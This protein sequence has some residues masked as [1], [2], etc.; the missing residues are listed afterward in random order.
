MAN[1]NEAWVP[2][3]PPRLLRDGV[4]RRTAAAVLLRA[5]VRLGRQAAE[6][7][8]LHDATRT[9]VVAHRGAL[10]GD[11]LLRAWGTPAFQA[12]VDPLSAARL[13]S[14]VGHA[15]S[16]F[17]L[18]ATRLDAERRAA[19]GRWADRV[20]APAATR[21]FFRETAAVNRLP[22]RA[23]RLA[24][25]GAASREP[26]GEKPAAAAAAAT[27]TVECPPVPAG[28]LRFADVTGMGPVKTALLEG[29]VWPF[30]YGNLYRTAAAGVLLYGLP[31]TGKTFV[32]RAAVTEL[33][34]RL[35]EA[36]GDASASAP[37]V[38][39]F[40]LRADAVKSKYVGE[41]ERRLAEFFRCVAARV[42]GAEDDRAKGRAIVFVDEAEAL[43]PRRDA[44][45]DDAG[46]EVGAGLVQTFLTLV[47]GVASR[48]PVSLVLASNLPG[49][50][51][52][53]VLRRLRQRVLVPLPTGRDIQHLLWRR[54]LRFLCYGLPLDP[55][56]L[57]ANPVRARY[58]YVQACP[59]LARLYED[60]LATTDVQ[61]DC[62]ALGVSGGSQEPQ[63]NA[64]V[65][66]DLDY[67]ALGL[68][69]DADDE[70][71]EE[72][73]VS[74]TFAFATQLVRQRASH[75][76]VA[77]FADMLVAAAG[78][79]ALEGRV[80]VRVAF[81]TSPGASEN[82]TT[83]RWVEAAHPL[84]PDS[85]FFAASSSPSLPRPAASVLGG[86]VQTVHLKRLDDE[87][88][89]PVVQA[90]FIDVDQR[91]RGGLVWLFTQRGGRTQ[92]KETQTPAWNLVFRE[93]ILP[94]SNRQRRGKREL[95]N[96]VFISDGYKGASEDGFLK[97]LSFT[98]VGTSNFRLQC[99]LSEEELDLPVILRSAPGF[100]AT[101]VWVVARSPEGATPERA[102]LLQ[103]WI[104]HTTRSPALPRTIRRQLRALTLVT[105]DAVDE[106]WNKWTS[107]WDQTLAESLAQFSP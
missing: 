18:L 79:V 49:Q 41:S 64:A 78:E 90:D 74:G 92:E 25:P 45:G 77:R 102:R 12:A 85:P 1:S 106:T 27:A 66:G 60:L 103:L 105:P 17:H 57:A 3:L 69:D 80:F 32:A 43:F 73:T 61:A 46:A 58:Q 7:S 100:P 75:S 21:Y 20:Q 96:E 55:D 72:Q 98:G 51:D 13:R 6:A 89:H 42:D 97:S 101:G 88:A 47:D 95:R 19:A 65:A 16:F 36:L 14:W 10:L 35:G 37:R 52:P 50:L 91:R 82:T 76:D 86:A 53:A 71:A 81:P 22:V 68:T 44:G 63:G 54:V 29:F 24:A 39:L 67:G 62:P 99:T 59:T 11:L 2:A 40:E 83:D 15:A 4:R 70:A 87:N 33:A 26:P 31:G 107:S 23:R 84:L 5:F 94:R 38:Q 8:T 48:A 28:G 93:T 56:A 9:A 104:P 34:A 30:V